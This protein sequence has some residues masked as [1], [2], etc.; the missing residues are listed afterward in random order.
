MA[1][2]AYPEHAFGQCGTIVPDRDGK[3]PAFE[4]RIIGAGLVRCGRTGSALVTGAGKAGYSVAIGFLTTSTE[5]G[6][7]F[8]TASETEPIS[9]RLTKP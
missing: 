7:Y 5:H 9:I 3:E 1:W 2:A 6:A 8:T 4:A